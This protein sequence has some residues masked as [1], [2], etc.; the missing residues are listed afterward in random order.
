MRGTG[1]KSFSGQPEVNTP[2]EERHWEY[3]WTQDAGLEAKCQEL[4]SFSGVEVSE[5]RTKKELQTRSGKLG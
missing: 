2:E 4:K 5:E 3:R 1:R